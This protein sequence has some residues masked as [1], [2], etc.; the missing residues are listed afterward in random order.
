MRRGNVLQEIENIVQEAVQQGDFCGVIVDDREYPCL[1]PVVGMDADQESGQN[2]VHVNEST[3]LGYLPVR[4]VVNTYPLPSQS[5]CCVL[6]EMPTGVLKPQPF[7]EGYRAEL[8][9]VVRS[10]TKKFEN[11][12]GVIRQWNEF[13][14]AAPQSDDVDEYLQDHPLYIPFAKELFGI[15]VTNGS[16][17]S[18]LIAAQKEADKSKKISSFSKFGELE[19]WESQPSMSFQK[20]APSKVPYKRQMNE[21]DGGDM[22]IESESDASSDGDGRWCTARRDT[23][24]KK[25]GNAQAYV[26]R[27]FTYK[28]NKDDSCS[29]AGV[30]VS[31]VHNTDVRNSELH[32]Q[33]YNSDDYPDGPPQDGDEYLYESCAVIMS[34]SKS[35]KFKL[36]PIPSARSTAVSKKRRITWAYVPV[37]GDQTEPAELS[38]RELRSRQ[39]SHPAESLPIKHRLRGD[40]DDICGD[41]DDDDDEDEEEEYKEEGEDEEEDDDEEE[42]DDDDEEEEEDDEENEEEKE[43]DNNTARGSSRARHSVAP[44]KVNCDTSMYQSFAHSRKRTIGRQSLSKY[45]DTYRPN[46]SEESSDED[47]DERIRHAAVGPMDPSRAAGSSV[48]ASSKQLQSVGDGDC[49]A[50]DDSDDCKGTD[51]SSRIKSR[52][53]AKASNT[54][55]QS[56][57]NSLKRAKGLVGGMK[58]V[59]PIVVTKQ[60][61]GQRQM[62]G[63]NSMKRR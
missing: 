4:L 40:D 15:G 22:E 49:D 7:I 5:P 32:F 44:A 53:H 52:R 46:R 24:V 41:D 35:N 56:L 63:L 50:D 19:I 60:S 18:S 23:K 6:R 25:Y 39:R 14:A 2:E 47:E 42:E 16:D 48:A 55:L 1:Q 61:N 11:F 20:D 54:S 36:M 31:V 62:V 33:Y 17:R 28:R 34:T 38:E 27:T 9:K 13:S 51:R 30:I 29:S 10:S 45:K 43:D 37:S 59:K 26:G 3:E 8:D 21:S 58:Y 12:A 57:T